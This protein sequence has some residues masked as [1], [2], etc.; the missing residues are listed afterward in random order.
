MR[1]RAPKHSTT[2]WR[3]RS[4]RFRISS[5]GVGDPRTTP[6]PTRGLISKDYAKQ[7]AKLIDSKAAQCDPAP[8][9]PP[10]HGNTVYLSVVDAEGNIVSWIQSISDIFGSGVVVD[11][12]GF[13]LHD[14]AG[15]MTFDP[16]HPN[17]LAPHKGPYHTI[18]PGF[19]EQGDLRI[20]FGIMRGMN[21]A[22]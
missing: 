21:Q 16:L 18:I 15:G 20:G 12:M 3:H 4:W 8:G 11:G 6:V 14:R 13:H 1:R 19:M 17:V 7:R 5:D 2:R 10:G 9:E 22:Q